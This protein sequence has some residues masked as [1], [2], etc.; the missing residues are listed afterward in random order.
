M[1][2]D[3]GNI[4]S[5]QSF[6]EPTL[7]CLVVV[8]GRMNTA[9]CCCRHHH[10]ALFSLIERRLEEKSCC[11]QMLLWGRAARIGESPML[12]Q[13]NVANRFSPSD[14]PVIIPMNSAKK[15]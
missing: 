4:S 13:T 1:T 3:R 6:V 11:L 12:V 7:N 5:Q 9:V 8:V 10:H 15:K 14:Y 2:F